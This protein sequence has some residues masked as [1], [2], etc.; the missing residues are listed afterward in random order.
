MLAGVVILALGVAE[1]KLLWYSHTRRD[2]GN[3]VQGLLLDERQRLAGRR[4][5]KAH[6][7]RAD[8]FVLDHV[9]GAHASDTNGV[10]GFVRDGR[11]GDFVVL[12]ETN[13][14]HPEVVE[15]RKNR[16]HRL[17]GYR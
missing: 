7:N 10:E 11:R 9:V 12:S 8:R 13:D 6:W 3:T 2:L 14:E 1:G 16:S 17:C 5:F 4:V 15:I